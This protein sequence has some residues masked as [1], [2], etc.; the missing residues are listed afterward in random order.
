M[1][2]REEGTEEASYEEAPAD[3]YRTYALGVQNQ[4]QLKLGLIQCFIQLRV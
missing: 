1:A 2:P 4:E 3:T